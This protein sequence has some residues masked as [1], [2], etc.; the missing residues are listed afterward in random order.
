MSVHGVEV[1]L[2]S[3]NVFDCVVSG[4]LG[5]LFCQV[6][7]FLEILMLI[8]K[9]LNQK[10]GLLPLM[11]QSADRH[12]LV[13]HFQKVSTL[14]IRGCVLVLLLLQ[15]GGLTR[16]LAFLGNSFL[17]LVHSLA[18]NTRWTF[19][20]SWVRTLAVTLGLLNILSLVLPNS[21]LIHWHLY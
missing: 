5:L 16:L 9:V 6:E 1:V 7:P 13:L 3:Q 10:F 20:W 11:V 15:L 2:Q 8:L 19:L 17:H 12:L 21:I 4:G 18:Q 14:G